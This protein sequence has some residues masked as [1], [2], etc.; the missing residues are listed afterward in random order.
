MTSLISARRLGNQML[1]EA[2]HRWPLLPRMAGNSSFT[3][4]VRT[5]PKFLLSI[6]WV[7]FHLWWR[8]L[9]ANCVRTMPVRETFVPRSAWIRNCLQN[10]R[11]L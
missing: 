11:R 2:R 3:I 9:A 5:I 8:W 7:P 10:C 4:G 6:C 1:T